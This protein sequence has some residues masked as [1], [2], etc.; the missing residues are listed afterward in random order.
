MRKSTLQLLLVA[1]LVSLAGCGKPSA[2]QH[3]ANAGK[4]LANN[5]VNSATIEAKNAVQLKPE[6]PAAR[7]MLGR[8]LSQAGNHR[9]AVIELERALSLGL[10]PTEGIPLLIKAYLAQG[11]PDE[12]IKRYA[13]FAAPD[14]P[15]EAHDI[16]VLVAE[17]YL[18]RND[19]KQAEATAREVIRQD[20]THVDARL[21]LANVLSVRGDQTPAL[22]L[23]DEVLAQQPDQPTALFQK[24]ELLRI[25]GKTD[26][27][28]PLY[29]RSLALRPR[30]APA[31]VGQFL[32]RLKKDDLDAAGKTLEQLQPL[33][34]QRMA[35]HVHR[36][37][38]EVARNDLVAARTHVEQ[39]LKLNPDSGAALEIA[40]YI[41]LREGKLVTAERYLSKA[42]AAYPDRLPSRDML[43]R[44][45][46]RMNEPAKAVATVTPLLSKAPPPSVLSLAG[47]AHLANGQMDKAEQ[48]FREAAKTL[49]ADGKLQTSLAITAAAGNA[50]LLLDKLRTASESNS[51]AYPDFALFAAQVRQGKMAEALKTADVLERKGV[52]KSVTA[53]LRGEVAMLMGQG[54]QARE[55]FLASVQ[56]DPAYVPPQMN[57]AKLDMGENHRE[58]AR[59]RLKQII[60]NDN[61]NIAA[62]MALARLARLDG[63]PAAEL[64]RQLTEIVDL[65]PEAAAPVRELVDHLIR[66][67]NAASA[68]DVARAGVARQRESLET[69]DT[70]GM[71]LQAAGQKEQAATTFRKA[72]SLSPESPVAHLRLANLAALQGDGAAAEQYLTAVLQTSP[73]LTEARLALLNRYLETSRFSEASRL[74]ADYQKAAP[75]SPLAWVWQGDIE[76][77]RKDLGKAT[78][79]YQKAYQAE[80]NDA[81]AVKLHAALTAAGRQ[82]EADAFAKARLAQSSV[83]PL[84][85]AHLGDIALASKRWPEAE[86]HYRAALAISDKQP[87]TLNNLA[88]VLAKT[89]NKEAESMALKAVALAPDQPALLDTLATTQAA[90]GK[91]DEAIATQRKAVALA[92]AQV[93]WRLSLARLLV[94]SRD[95]RGA[96]AEFES[97]AS[98]AR[99]SAAQ[100]AEAQK[101]LAEL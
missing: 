30:H 70:L 101:A 31:L 22:A 71:A 39:A 18:M 26:E 80:A 86:Q 38:L 28:L 56:A 3:L 61:K 79:L 68:V 81:T 54:K 49:P 8:A 25:A 7:L 59:K 6:D 65:N 96:R 88:W 35:Y 58:D 32:A 92:P 100:K 98:N 23:V 99:A 91:M 69:L 63:A 21:M 5:E 20:P 95:V 37:Q 17:A 29:E 41:D 90:A 33:P 24:A 60:A 66:S 55:H 2:E 48:L 42:L 53:N 62:R 94:R 64:T 77:R 43:T 93:E 45:Y 15:K 11:L 87:A 78:A 75:G 51:S 14:K 57:L 84:F 10:A 83:T 19:L 27:A 85:H 89:G 97:V 82:S 4:F 34:N 50:E 73:A 36:A 47:D 74:V 52:S 72:A 9:E 40:G 44:T 67:G 13:K 16:Q 1:G 46:L 12:P 76:A